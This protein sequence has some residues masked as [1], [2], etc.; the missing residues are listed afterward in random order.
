MVKIA[1]YVHTWNR[2]GT[3]LSLS[4]IISEL[5][6]DEF[7]AWVLYDEQKD[8]PL[9]LELFKHAHFASYYRSKSVDSLGYPTESDIERVIMKT[10]KPDILHVARS[11]RTEWPLV[12]RYASLQIENN[13]FGGMDR[14]GFIDRTVCPNKYVSSRRGECDAIIPHPIPVIVGNPIEVLHKCD[15]PNG[16][17]VCGRVGRTGWFHP[18]AFDAFKAI[19]ER[20]EN[21]YFLLCSPCEE[22]VAYVERNH[23]Q[24]VRYIDPINNDITLYN[25][26][27]ACDIFLHYC[28]GGET[29]SNCILEAMMCGCPVISHISGNDDGHIETMGDTGMIAHN[30]EEYREFLSSLV[31]DRTIRL[32]AGARARERARTYFAQSTVVRE[33]ERYYK[34]WLK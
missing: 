10:V 29:F 19:Q 11:G 18:W 32:I 5:N 31:K 30:A 20:N 9:I 17:L 24:N 1:Y 21:L 33:Y 2:R 23:I 28:S 16:A 12:K 27:A 8:N 26:Y 25:F 15:I 14:S 4:R 6:S 3:P 13:I 7:E 22:A 34:E